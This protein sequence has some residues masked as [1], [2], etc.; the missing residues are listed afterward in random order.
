MGHRKNGC[1][2]ASTILPL[3]FMAQ[4]KY[5]QCWSP[6]KWHVSWVTTWNIQTNQV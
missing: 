1:E 2:A 5:Q 3:S 4:W 6:N